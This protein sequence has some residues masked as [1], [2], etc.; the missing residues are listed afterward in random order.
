METNEYIKAKLEFNR[1]LCAINEK[2][3]GKMIYL[4]NLIDELSDLGTY[5]REHQL[6]GIIDFKKIRH[7]LTNLNYVFE[8]KYKFIECTSFGV[9]LESEALPSP[10]QYLFDLFLKFKY[11]EF[12][13]IMKG[14]YSG[15][16]TIRDCLNNYSSYRFENKNFMDC[17]YECACLWAKDRYNSIEYANDDIYEPLYR[18]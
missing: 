10:H 15:A 14:K 2:Y 18:D 16:F 8:Y 3:A 11:D 13:F 17:Y 5:V 4:R 7:T 9:L 12:Y 1:M 6:S